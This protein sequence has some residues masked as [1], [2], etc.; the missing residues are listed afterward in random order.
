MRTDVYN[1]NN[2]EDA[3]H[4]V[5]DG[6]TDDDEVQPAPGITE[7][8]YDTHGDQLKAGLQEEDHG[9]D[10][11]QVVESIHQQRSGLEPDVL[12]G[13]DEAAHQDESQDHRL[14]IFVLNQPER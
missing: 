1:S 12:Q 4:K 3:G 10:L 7:V 5:D 2:T 8:S 11:V 13:H 14:E 9:E 6:D